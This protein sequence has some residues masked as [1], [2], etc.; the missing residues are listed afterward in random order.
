MTTVLITGAD[1]FLGRNLRAHLAPRED[2]RLFCFDLANTAE[3]LDRFLTDA[4]VV[5]HLAGV[6]RPETVEEYEVGNAGFTA[7]LCERLVAVG[8]APKIVFSSSIQAEMAN[9]YGQSKRKAEEVLEAHSRRTGA[10]VVVYRFANLYGKWS[11]PNYNSVVATFSHDIARDLPITVSDPVRIIDLLYV[12]DAVAALVGDVEPGDTAG[13]RVAQAGPVTPI[14]LGDLAARIRS[15]RDVR[16]SLF[17]PDLSERLTVCLY[18]TYLSYLPE[19]AFAYGLE[20]R[21]DERGG[22]AEFLKAAPMGQIFLSRTH[23]GITRGN[24]YHHTKTEKFLVLE[25]EALI[26][27]R[28]VLADDVIEYRVRGD[29][30]RV[31]DIPPG[32]THSITNVGAA[33]LITLFW[34]SEPLDPARPDT[35][36]EEV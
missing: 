10:E 26:R 25:G 35:F 9:P 11:R 23:P 12:D 4:D 21:S 8:R 19:D 27:F 30:F 18:A 31:V 17:L 16:G 7:T 20:V 3:E 15:F 24:H 33:E 32:Y 14:A 22:L 6:N 2:L 36:P 29:E 28:H 13:F 5:Y 1:G 34:A